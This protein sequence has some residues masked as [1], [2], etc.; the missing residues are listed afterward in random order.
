MSAWMLFTLGFDEQLA[1]YAINYNDLHIQ[2]S[3]AEGVYTWTLYE[4]QMI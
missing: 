1:P 4:T 3:I 2:E